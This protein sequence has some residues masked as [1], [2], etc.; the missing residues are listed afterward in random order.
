MLIVTTEK[1]QVFV[2]AFDARTNRLTTL[3]AGDLR[4][5]IGQ[6]ALNG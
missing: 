3:A 5:R 4:D 6:P 1:H 2:V